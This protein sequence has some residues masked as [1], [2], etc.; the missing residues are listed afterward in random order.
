MRRGRILILF[1]LLLA[2]GVVVFYMLFGRPAGQP[3]A[4]GTPAA[5]VTETTNIVMALQEIPRGAEITT[6]MVGLMPFPRDQ[7]VETMIENDVTQVIGRHAR[8][9]IPQGSPITTNMITMRPG[10]IL[11]A[12]S[13]AAMA[14]PFGY[15]AISIPMTRLSG[16]AYALRPGDMVDVI[17][18]MLMVDLDPE[19]QSLL[20]DIAVLLI[21]P[22]V[23][24]RTGLICQDL[25]WTERGPQ[26]T[27]PQPVQMGRA[28]TEEGTGTPM[29]LVPSETQRPRL[30]T[31]R[32][33]QNASVLHVGS[34]T[35]EGETEATVPVAVTEGQAGAQATQTAPTGPEPPDIVTLIVS[36]QD[37]LALNWAV[38]SGSYVTLT[39]RA[40]GDTAVTE[41]IS[42][43][44]QYLMQNYS[45]TVPTRLPYGL[46]PA[47][48][49]PIPPVLPNDVPPV[50][51]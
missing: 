30:V 38:M 40:P 19:F 48:T 23:T 42:V 4:G 51:P 8:M 15:T 11:G 25:S 20:P 45:I 13:D 36:P 27:N 10:D 7:V 26:C 1:G 47:V 2:V 14:I 6:D 33:I 28:D 41:T 16:V 32:L 31:Q 21:G 9:G 43:T 3:P 44:L 35:F 24:L 37:A 39:L 29:L 17:V 34:F 49:S 12:G 46:Q 22:D 5:P 50:E 18:T